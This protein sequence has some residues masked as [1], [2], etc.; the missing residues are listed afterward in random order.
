[1]RQ[2]FRRRGRVVQILLH[3]RAQRPLVALQRQRVVAALG[4]DRRR[5]PALRAQRV[6]RHRPPLHVHQLQ[7][8]RQ[9][10]YLVRLAVHLHLRQRQLRLRRECLQQ[11]RRRPFRGVLE[12]PPQHLAVHRDHVAEPV[13]PVLRQAQQ[14]LLETCRVQQSE[15]PRERVVARNP[16]LKR[17]KLPQPPLRG[18][19]V[20]LHLD[21]RASARERRQQRD[22][23]HLV[24]VVALGVAS[25]RV[26]NFLKNKQ[27][28]P[29]SVSPSLDRDAYSAPS[30]L[31]VP[32]H[33]IQMR[34]PWLAGPSCC[35]S[36]RVG[37]RG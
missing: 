17:Q 12:R 8:L 19:S 9:R 37:G 21:A 1:M 23:Q 4:H 7:Q 13:R 27:K 30:P 14:R 28:F 11:V 5:R 36:R 34:L 24:Q 10:R 33:L 32:P 29:H 16:V 22:H 31:S 25:P 15:Q 26:L 2:E 20:V 35:R 18:A 3:V 6:R